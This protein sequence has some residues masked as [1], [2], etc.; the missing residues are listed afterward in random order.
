MS[1]KNSQIE[2]KLQV[3]GLTFLAIHQS[4]QILIAD[5]TDFEEL[6][7]TDDVR[8]LIVFCEKLLS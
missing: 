2:F 3:M 5:D 4:F 7:P 8:R 1:T 6:L